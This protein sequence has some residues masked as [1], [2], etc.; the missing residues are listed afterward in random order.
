MNP[1]I[2]HV[3]ARETENKVP[4]KENMIHSQSVGPGGM[5]QEE[6][7]TLKYCQETVTVKSKDK[8]EL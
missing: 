2:K 5:R 4:R 7:W 8:K 1:M 3:K 6:N